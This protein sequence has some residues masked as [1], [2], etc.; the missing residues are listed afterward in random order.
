MDPFTLFVLF[1]ILLSF[2]L[3]VFFFAICCVV[4][5]FRFILQFLVIFNQLITMSAKSFQQNISFS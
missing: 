4:S 3:V 5:F 1:S 2:L